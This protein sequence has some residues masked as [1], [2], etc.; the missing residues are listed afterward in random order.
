[1]RAPRCTRALVLWC[2]FFGIVVAG[3]LRYGILPS[4]E[5]AGGYLLGLYERARTTLFYQMMVAVF[6][7]CALYSM[8]L[9][10]TLGHWLR[11][12]ETGAPG[13]RQ[14]IAILAGLG[15]TGPGA[16]D[17]EKAGPVALSVAANPVRDA[18]VLFPA[19]GFIGTVVGVSLAIGGL[20]DV[21]DSGETA[22]LLEGLRI[23]FDTTLIGL[24]ASV[25]LTAL[26]HLVHARS[27]LLRVKTGIAG[28]P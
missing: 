24:V 25:V 3:L 11:D 4:A 28:L 16:R 13:T 7:G 20:S 1:M 23:A 18:T 10:I 22:P 17:W 5:G 27:T 6:F 8:A 21:L 14:W 2:A 12:P 9:I 26:L 19:V 15:N